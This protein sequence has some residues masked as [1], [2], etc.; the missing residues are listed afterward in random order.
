M[1]ETGENEHKMEREKW[2][3]RTVFTHLFL[4]PLWFPFNYSIIKD[5]QRDGLAFIFVFVVKHISF[6]V[7]VFIF[8]QSNV[9]TTMGIYLPAWTCV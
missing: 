5:I 1:T 2:G 7:C 9:Q 4:I 8:Q 6:Y 3:M